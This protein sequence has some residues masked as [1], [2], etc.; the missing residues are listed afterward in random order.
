M[1]D[2][3]VECLG[4][5]LAVEGGDVVVLELLR[6]IGNEDIDLAKLGNVVLDE[7]DVVGFGPEVKGDKVRGASRCLGRN[8][9]LH[10]LCILLLAGQVGNG[11]VGTLDGEEDGDGSANTRVTSAD[12]SLLALEL[13]RADVRLAV[14]VQ[15]IDGLLRGG[16]E[17]RGSAS[18]LAAV[19]S[20]S[21]GLRIRGCTHQALL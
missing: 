19:K 15:V 21:Y 2:V 4:P 12:D 11:A 14:G 16:A 5:L 7:L 13:A 20:K 1:V 9:T 3:D 17:Y 8:V 10:V 6:R 18:A